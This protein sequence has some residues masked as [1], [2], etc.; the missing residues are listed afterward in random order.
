MGAGKSTVG[1][2][3]AD[4]LGR[5]FVDTDKLI[6]EKMSLSASDI[7]MKHS[8]PYFR[9]LERQVGLQLTQTKHQIIATGG[10][11]PVK[12]FDVK[13]MKRSGIV[14]QLFSPLDMM[15]QRVNEAKDVSRPLAPTKELFVGRYKKRKSIYDQADFTVSTNRT[16]QETVRE[17][18]FMI[19]QYRI[20]SLN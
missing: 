13:D 1:A 5:T 2:R 7:I 9:I 14:I 15:W 12:A 10:G 6:A 3:L 17:L 20:E 4:E 18:I 19:D 16:I 8:E 11:F